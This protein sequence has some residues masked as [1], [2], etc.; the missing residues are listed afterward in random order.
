MNRFKALLLL[1]ALTATRS[2]PGDIVD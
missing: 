2:R 1:A